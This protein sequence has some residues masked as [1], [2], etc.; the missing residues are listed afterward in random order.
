MS[1]NNPHVIMGQE[2]KGS[3][4]DGYTIEIKRYQSNSNV[5]YMPLATEMLAD[6]QSDLERVNRLINARTHRLSNK[7]EEAKR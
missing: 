6:L 1:R 3:T 7:L 2:V 5:A 4:K